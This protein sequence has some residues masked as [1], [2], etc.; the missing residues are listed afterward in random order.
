MALGSIPRHSHPWKINTLPTYPPQTEQRPPTADLIIMAWPLTV[1]CKSLQTLVNQLHIISIDIEAEQDQAT[2]GDP[3]DTIQET[4][5]LQ[6]EVV[7]VL[8]AD[9]LA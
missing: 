5:G 7:A 6:D 2:C 3:T 8:T 9:L 1:L 4:E